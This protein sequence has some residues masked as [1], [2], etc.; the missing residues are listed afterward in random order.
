M[1]IEKL[2][3]HV[4]IVLAPI[5]SYSFFFEKKQVSTSPYL[6]GPCKVSLQHFV[7][8]LLF[9]KETSIGIYGTPLWCLPFFMEV[10]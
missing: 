1:L 6:Y 10:E 9:T 3:L 5:L 7:F 2:L 4:L 8:C